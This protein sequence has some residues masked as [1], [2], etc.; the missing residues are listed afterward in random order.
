MPGP[1]IF[2]A[3]NGIPERLYRHAESLGRARDEQR[4]VFLGHPM[5]G[6]DTAREILRRLRQIDDR[7]SLHVYGGPRLWGQE[8]AEIEPEPGLVY[9][10]L[11]GQRRLAG[12]GV[13][14]G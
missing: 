8:E 7:Y 14:A 11:L 6:L 5:K 3:Y 9:H 13:P 2:F 4:L 10:G 12:E 1:S